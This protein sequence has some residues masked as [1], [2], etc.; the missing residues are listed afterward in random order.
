[1][2]LSAM[3]GPA[4][5]ARARWHRRRRLPARRSQPQPPPTQSRLHTSGNKGRRWTRPPDQG[6][7]H[8]CSELAAGRVV[9]TPD[10]KGLADQ[11][12]G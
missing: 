6:R 2:L 8:F 12:P 10:E 9:A 7:C 11:G 4:R 3:P 1:M 5:S